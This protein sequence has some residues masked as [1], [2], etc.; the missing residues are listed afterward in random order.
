MCLG[1][2][3]SGVGDS[4]EQV[5]REPALMQPTCPLEG[6]PENKYNTIVI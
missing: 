5:M 1:L 2:I 6:Q 3:V 4:T